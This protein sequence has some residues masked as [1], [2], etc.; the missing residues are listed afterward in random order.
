[1]D[2]LHELHPSPSAAPGRPERDA[3]CAPLTEGPSEPVLVSLH[4]EPIDERRARR[5]WLW[6]R[7]LGLPTVWEAS[8]AP[9]PAERAALDESEARARWAA[10][11][12]G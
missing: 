1:M 4:P 10:R 3:R 12:V 11:Q 7:E 5:R 2:S 6:R 8:A 9:D